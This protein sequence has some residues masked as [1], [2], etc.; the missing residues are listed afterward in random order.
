MKNLPPLKQILQSACAWIFWLLPLAGFPL[1]FARLTGR[2]IPLF[3]M[4]QLVSFPEL[5]LI[6]LAIIALNFNRLKIFLQQSEVLRLSA[7]ASTCVVVAGIIQQFL[8]GGSAE[9][10]WHAFFYASTPLAAAAIAPELR[11]ILPKA[12]PLCA[13]LLL[14]SGIT[15]ESFTGLAGNWNWNQILFFAML[16]GFF[17]RFK[18]VDGIKYSLMAMFFFLA[19]GSLFYP[20]QLSLTLCIILP[21]TMVGMWICN[22][23][24][25]QNRGRSAV[26]L[27]A[28]LLTAVCGAAMWKNVANI[29]DSRVQLFASTA[30]LLNRHWFLGVGP[31]RFFDF[32]QKYITPEYFLA[33]F[34]A[35]H[36]P[37]P[38]NE[39]LHLW[40]SFGVSGIFF[41]AVLFYGVLKSFPRRHA[42]LRCLLPVWIFLLIFFCGQTD[43]TAAILAGS[44]WMLVSAGITI[45]PYKKMP[46]SPGK[47]GAVIAV[48]LV[49]AAAIMAS[50]NL[51]CSLLLRRGRLAALAGDGAAAVKYYLD[52]IEIKPTKEALYGC[53]EIALHTRQDHRTALAF[54]EKMHT[55]LRVDNYLHTNRIKA[56][57]QV[58]TGNLPEALKSIRRELQ[59]YPLSVINHR[60]HCDLLKLLRR[61]EMEI[62]E[63][64]KEYA[65]SCRL[66]RISP[67]RGAQI[68]MTEDDSPL[69]ENAAEHQQLT[70]P[71]LFPGIVHELISAV[72]L[73]F[74]VLG[75]GGFLCRRVRCN[76]M[77][78]TAV[79]IAGCAVA[80]A[81]IAPSYIPLILVVPALCGIYCNFDRFR[82]HWKL[83]LC[84]I[85]LTLFMLANALLPPNSW[86]EQVYHISLLKTY[87]ANG[88]WHKITDNPYSAYPSLV[89]AFLLCNFD[90]GGATLPRL[91]SLLFYVLSGIC[92][93]KFLSRR[94]GKFGAGSVV[95]A[96]LVSPLSLLL[97]RNFYAEP[98]I[99][100]F[101]IAGIS[102][103]S[104]A[105]PPGKRECF[106]AG[107]V[108]GAAVSVKLTGGGS[109][110][111]IFVFLLFRQR[112]WRHLLSF[113]GGFLIPA[114]LFFSRIWYFYGNPFYPFGSKWFGAPET[115]VLVE[116]FHRTL[117]GHYGLDALS[118]TIYG[119]LFNALK[120]ELYDGVSG[121]FQL[122][123]FFVTALAGAYLAGRRDKEQRAVWFGAAASLL[124]AYL[125]WG[126]TARQTRFM[127]PVFFGSALVAILCA[128]RLSPFYKKILAALALIA[129]V[130]S[131]MNSNGLLMHY[132]F[133]ARMLSGARKMP[134][135]F[136]AIREN[137]YTRLLHR[138]NALPPDAK[139]AMLTERRTLYMP[140]P[141]TILMP[142]FQEKL[143]PVPDSAGELFRELAAFDYI[144]I[145]I[146]TSDVD[147]APEYDD[148]LNKLYMHIHQLL[149]EG[150]L[151]VLP[152]SEMTILRVVTSAAGNA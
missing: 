41:I 75:I 17:I 36:H 27:F 99:L 58:N 71:G 107:C 149:R 106:I 16:P 136:A 98:F 101:T 43:L 87:A 138:V 108:A 114:V 140:R 112:N 129:S 56:V 92:L 116:E 7:W 119:W 9:H 31:G 134:A 121:G 55:E 111:A 118:G 127:Y 126:M 123:L 20:E 78:E 60:L 44:F 53:A 125:F 65:N 49:A 84:F 150:K 113:C 5:A 45:A 34:S 1:A 69:P 11:R 132:Y 152:D 52:S 28:L 144:I 38:H 151:E 137:G 86:D 21:L 73:F 90:W 77:V 115:A 22:R 82:C 33:P 104:G 128:E 89:H 124:A 79:G 83:I 47:S 29:Y 14:L 131:L 68:T 91:I 95:F 66:R 142:H 46:F 4:V 12:A 8:Y 102:V 50:M 146:P 97:V 148:E 26:I 62:E 54:L 57:A 67:V 103:L 105:N 25:R 10:L 135:G 61:P 74:A 122:P 81:L 19:A 96:L 42:N 35:L 94:I 39:L 76:I 15:S 120:P 3:G 88:F 110:L 70:Y 143:T 32:I 117:G 59:A 80:G 63:A 13:G 6:S 93:F 23:F 85:L 139:I 40:S 109:A 30:K 24:S 2:K 51:Q 147:R 37:H 72:T 48:L 145:R 130:I 18:L 100:L 64:F 133:S 141:V